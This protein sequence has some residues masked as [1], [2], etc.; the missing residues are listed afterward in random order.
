MSR[1]IGE[2]YGARRGIP[3]Q[4][5]VEV[6]FPP[7]RAK[8]GVAEFESL[9]AKVLEQTPEGVQAFALT[10]AEPY[11]VGCMSVTTAFAMGYDPGYCA[12]G[13]RPTK[14]SPYY[15]STSHRPYTDFGI[16]PTMAIAALRFDEAKSLIDR[17]IESDASRPE[18]TAYLLKTSDKARSVRAERFAEAQKELGGALD[19]ELI[20]ADF[21][22]GR[23]DVLFYLTGSVRVRRMDT[24]RFLPGA[25]ADHLTSTGGK[26]T[27]S[28]QMSSLR[29]LEAGATGSYGAVVEPCNF[30]AKFPDA[31]V[32]LQ[33]YVTGATLIES[34]WKSVLMPGQGI[35]IGEPL[36]R[37]Y[38]GYQLSRQDGRWVLSTYAL[39]PGSYQ[40]E[41][42]DS[43]LGPYR[44]IETFSKPS[45]R[46]LEL[47]LPSPVGRYYRIVELSSS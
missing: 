2:Y 24:N 5:I 20:D 32:L 1:A 9:Y 26:L 31:P 11:Q 30:L 38:G 35:F 3:S 47:T 12:S 4:R 22:E 34:Y 40:L 7:N 41:G 36:A 25:I 19:I 43:P 10:W 46:K 37:P 29:W 27:Y 17:G 45:P 23:S 42:A 39:L 28:H 14:T 33:A 8:M 6:S 18:G 15:V 16:R 44:P 13:C 21:I